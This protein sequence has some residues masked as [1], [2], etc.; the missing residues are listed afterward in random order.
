[1]TIARSARMRTRSV[2]QLR[3]GRPEFEPGELPERRI[4]GLTLRG[5][6][7][8]LSRCYGAGTLYGPTPTVSTGVTVAMLQ[9]ARRTMW[10]T[11]SR[12][13]MVLACAVFRC[14]RSLHEISP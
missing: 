6:R 8:L 5:N 11:G 13:K 9:E 12:F 3:F 4:I 10:S 14:V 1:M 7:L 2:P